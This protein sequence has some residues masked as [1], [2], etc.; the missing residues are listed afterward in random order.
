MA[1]LR[2]Q[3]RLQLFDVVAVNALECE[4]GVFLFVPILT[5]GVEAR[6]AIIDI[7]R[8]GFSDEGRELGNGSDV[9]HFDGRQPVDFHE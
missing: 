3:A 2:R 5:G 7:K 9:A 8:A 1:E 4:A 6:L